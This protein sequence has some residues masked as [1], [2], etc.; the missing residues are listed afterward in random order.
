MSKISTHLYPHRTDKDQAFVDDMWIILKSPHWIVVDAG[1]SLLSGWLFFTAS[2]TSYAFVKDG[3]IARL[4]IELQ[5]HTRRFDNNE[6]FHDS[7]LFILHIATTF[8]TPS[9]I[10]S[11]W[12]RGMSESAPTIRD[13]ILKKVIVPSSQYVEHVFRHLIRTPALI[14]NMNV[15]NLILNVF[16]IAVRH[17]FTMPYLRTSSFTLTFTV[18]LFENCDGFDVRDF[19]VRFCIFSSDV[20]REGGEVRSGMTNLMGMLVS[21]GVE[22][23]LEE[24]QLDDA[25]DPGGQDIKESSLWLGNRLGWNGPSLE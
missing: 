11:L 6:L 12:E 20:N 21:E 17:P 5:P 18:L 7:L 3:Q 19:L 23:G 8:G 9:G 13:T 2:N 4:M 24:R 10:Y 22:D 14:R 15:P 1:V 25:N 16:D